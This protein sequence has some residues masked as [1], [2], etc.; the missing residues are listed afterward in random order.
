MKIHCE[1]LNRIPYSNLF[2]EAFFV[3]CKVRMP[4]MVIVVLDPK[5][6]RVC[7]AAKH[8]ELEGLTA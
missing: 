7:F 3:I 4:I 5:I 1:A 8:E 6:P 2:Q